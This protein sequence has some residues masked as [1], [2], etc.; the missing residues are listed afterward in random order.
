[1]T[2]QHGNSKMAMV[3]GVAQSMQSALRQD[4]SGL[5]LDV[6]KA[7]DQHLAYTEL[8]RRNLEQVIEIDADDNQPDCCFIEDTAIVHLGHFIL[9]RMGAPERRGETKGVRQ[10]FEQIVARTAP[11]IF[12]CLE[13]PTALDGGDVL[14]LGRDLFVGLSKRS[15]AAAVDSL[16][17]IFSPKGQVHAVPLSE[18][19][20]LKSVLTAIDDHTL[21]AADNNA[22]RLAA[23][24][25]VAGLGP[26]GR[27][28]VA[29]VPDALCANVLR[30]PSTLVVQQGYPRSSVILRRLG[31]ER[32]L[33]VTELDMSEFA[34]VDGALTC[35][36]ILF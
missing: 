34:K 28:E 11:L 31:E 20:H 32:Q 2:E 26:G 16:R 27:I 4:P 18:G 29:Y 35:C 3:R 19:L 21:V 10:A 33:D 22:G 5:V 7:R 15:N 8:L 13:L 30:L 12:H 1:M 36:S 23:A 14:R 17:A 6:A 25:V 9:C 24:S